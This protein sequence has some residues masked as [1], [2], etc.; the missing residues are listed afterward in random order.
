MAGTRGGWGRLVAMVLALLVA[1]FLMLAGEARAGFYNV[2]Q[3]GWGVGAD[4]DWWDSTG[5]VK[6]GPDAACGDH[7]RSST[8][9]AGTVSGERFARWRWVAPPTTGIRSFH[10]AWWHV[11]NDG[12]QERIGGWSAGGDFSPFI[13][14][15]ATA[16]AP[17]EFTNVFTPSVPVVEDRLLCARADTAS[18]ALAPESWSALRNVILMVDDGVPPGAWITGGSLTDGGWRR[19]AQSVDF[20]GHDDG[21]GVHLGETLIDGSRVGIDEYPCAAAVIEGGVWATR[22]R[23]CPTDAAGTLTLDT[24]HFT[25]GTHALSHCAYDFAGVE[26]CTPARSVSIDNNPPGAPDG[27]R[28]V[29]GEGWR[30][31]NDFTLEWGDPDQAPAGSIAGAY[32]RLL[33]PGG[34]DSAAQNYFAGVGIDKVADT[35]VPGEGVWTAWVWLR[36]EAGNADPASFAEV[37]MRLDMAPPSVVFE[38]KG[39]YEDQPPPAQVTALVA[40]PLS[41]PAGGTISYREVGTENFTDL[42]TKLRDDQGRTT[43]VAPTPPL[44]AG[45]WEF[46]AE[47][48]DAAGNS[49]STSA[50]ADGTRMSFHVAP[51]APPGGGDGKA[52]G[53]GEGGK[54][55]DGKAGR[56]GADGK[57]GGDGAGGGDASGAGPAGRRTRA[58]LFVRLRGGHGKGDA[59]TVPF[60]ARPLLSGRLTS[61]AGAGLAGRSVKVVVRPSHGALLPRTVEHL[62]TGGRGGF[63]LRLEPGTSR[64]LTVTFAGN[65]D[66]APASH[67]PL[68]LRVRS[69]V[70]L[71]A[72]PTTLRTGE[73]VHLSGLVRSRSAPIPRRGKLV[74]IQYL[75][76]DTGR[77]RPVLVTRTD[78]AGHFHARYRFRY[79]SGAARIRLRATALAE[80][81][82]PYAPGSSPPATVEVQG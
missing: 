69:G 66:L 57:D 3:C 35:G 7:L 72:A 47:A 64:R 1:I 50:R 9:G 75:E 32:L 54:G 49:A 13:G 15:A 70:T 65:G 62:R 28:V 56:A 52:P 53:K 23:P 2:V 14:S 39:G 19:G 61:V 21:S 71:V 10:A 42:P 18:C 77:W 17:S 68:D 31:T 29:G 33:G 58:R 40:D 55:A 44:A 8:R 63:A 38:G 26:A 79:I 6:F 5:G 36:D 80:E 67:R 34:F 11:L 37:H 43:L 45:N 30:R 25:D 59:L 16:P 76:S 20:A 41:G 22:M 60:L 78:H 27:L 48:T 24:A 81:R 74:A 12:F 4:A 73:S 46:R 51:P 82:W